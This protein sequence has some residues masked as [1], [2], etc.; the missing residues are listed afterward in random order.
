MSY[1]AQGEK[2][3]L[4]NLSEDLG[5]HLSEGL[6]L[7]QIKDV[8][9]G[10]ESYDEK[11]CKERFKAILSKRKEEEMRKEEQT[12]QDKE[13]EFELQKL[14]LNLEVQKNS[15]DGLSNMSDDDIPKYELKK[16]IPSFDPNAGD[17]ALYLNIF[18]RQLKF[19]KLPETKW[20]AYLIGLLPAEMAK[21]IARESEEESKDYQHV[22]TML[23]KRYKLSAE[24]FRQLFSTHRKTP[25]GTYRDFYFELRDYFE[26]WLEALNVKTFED[27]KSLIIADQIKKKTPE[28]FRTH[29]IDEW[30]EW[31]SPEELADKLDAYDNLR[32]TLKRDMT[33][34]KKKMFNPKGETT[35][36]RLLTKKSN[37]YPK[38]ENS[39]SDVQNRPTLTC[40]GC[41]EPGVIK[42]RCPKCNL[43]GTNS[44][45]R[46]GNVIFQSCSEKHS[47][48]AILNITVNGIF[49][50]ACADS[51]A[52]HCI[53]GELLY[54][55]LK[56][57]G[58]V[59]QK[60]QLTMTLADGGK[61]QV[62]AYKTC[63]DIG[64][65]GRTIKTNLIAL[66]HAKENRTLLGTDFL[67]D[68][69]V[70]LDLKGRKW[71]FKDVPHR[72]YD[73]GEETN[74]CDIK[75]T[76]NVESNTCKLR[77]EEGKQL[78]KE[79]K[80]Q[81]NT[82]LKQ[83]ETI[84]EPGGEDPTPYVEHFIKTQ[85]HP[86]VAVPPYRV[87]PARR[88]ILK[89]EIDRLLNDKIIEPCESPYAAPV[90]LVPKPNGS[91]RLCVDYRKLNSM[92][93]TDT[94]PLPRIDDLLQTARH[95]QFMSTIDLKSGY[96]QV[97]VAI[98]DRDKTAFT[99]PFGT[100]RFLR[101]PFGLKNAPATFQRLIDKFKNGLQ[102]MTILSYLDDI[103]I[104]SQTFEEHIENLRK[105]F[106]RL[107][108]FKLQA[109][110]EKCHFACSQVK[111]LGHYITPNGIEVD[112]EKT[113]AIQ[114]MPEPKNV[115]QVQSFLQTCSWYR[116]F[117]PKFSEIAR[118]LS[119]LTKKASPWRWEQE[120]QNAFNTLKELLVSPPI[121]KQCDPAKPYV[122]RTDASNFALGA[123]LSQGEVP[124]E[125]PIE[126]ASRLLTSA[127]KNYSTTEREALA[128]VWALQKFRGYIEGAEVTVASDHQ[129]LRWLMSLKSPSG[130][131]ARWALQ[132]QEF[133]LKIH[134][135]P[136]KS[137][138]IADMLSRPFN[139]NQCEIDHFSVDL[140]SRN[141]K[142]IRE[143]QLKDDKLRP[144]IES[145]ESTQ[146][147]ENY[148]NWTERGY[149]MNQGVLYR[150]VPDVDTEE[151]QLVVP[152]HEVKNVLQ[153]YH[154]AP[155]AGHYGEEG[156]YHR[157]SQRYYWTGMRPAIAD[158]VKKCPECARY[159][160]TNLKP[161]GLLRTPVQSQ[162]F[163]TLSIDLF[164]PLPESASGKRWIFIVEDCST[165][166]IE[167]FALKSATAKECAVT[168]V[169]EVFLRYGIP[170][171]LISDNGS[172]FI[173]A[174]LQQICFILKIEQSLTPVYHPQANPVERKN[175]DLKPRL[176][177]LVG[178]EH[179]NWEDKLPCIRF[180][181]NTHQCE[182]TGCT[183]AFLQFA[184]E[185]R[186]VDDIANDL[187]PI[188]END[189]FVPE[190]T[191]YLKR[192]SNIS[193]KIRERIEKKQ[194]QRKQQ[195][196]RRRRPLYFSPGDKVWVTTHPKSNASKSKTA[197][198]MPK[199]DGPYVIT[200]QRSPTTYEV[201][202][203][204]K[205]EVPMG[206]YH[207]S[208]LTK[209]LDDNVVPV[210]PL[211]R[212]GRPRNLD[213]SHNLSNLRR[214]KRKPGPSA[215]R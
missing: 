115:K 120:E 72:K 5:I 180:A 7:V 215:R 61:S 54:K 156:T 13:R 190:I 201:A 154:D 197:K 205:P 202:H 87:S 158:Y 27:L 147:D 38:K 148:V 188:I 20:V 18:E 35:G 132:I 42:S 209:C 90:V 62:E 157:I 58:A 134:Y 110:R 84:F 184:R 176:A 159:K 111:Y 25:E 146:R 51:G 29:F 151:A 96:H 108:E 83:Y 165:R 46:F 40:Y 6:T 123:V 187:T 71:F 44:S 52:S 88:E 129:P 80:S 34:V 160:A 206:R 63:V 193:N 53:A 95:T 48:L 10:H 14:K 66:P 179:E 69:G 198:F 16:L 2:E 210:A 144:I 170:R 182:T 99:C 100:Y 185:L 31:N 126:Y 166:W 175:R 23:L 104:L 145:F 173:S 118:P 200:T 130:R 107:R 142:E 30:T 92:T 103:I 11:F 1:L 186:T 167:L 105:V 149:L 37:F 177:I 106:Q 155:T 91:F 41:G 65:E 164:G 140:P 199:R 79:E 208:A 81:L 28:D 169:E 194:D 9:V 196:D 39:K 98:K 162:R 36:T 183:P 75:S 117:I 8:I 137:N 12:R 21:L 112:P 122:I 78:S 212:R 114:N 168:L 76:L 128:V 45:A 32:T 161:A 189:N 214:S 49:G 213:P 125:H 43:S 70:V 47:Q 82:L 93:E 109:N 102:D 141:P 55:I 26:G 68:A 163:E 136:G 116:R 22:K 101:M 57:E 3:D 15:V 121:L 119:N 97:G 204:D 17:I 86:P 85:N 192:F 207:V 127:E 150:F 172:Q 174:V 153:Q 135:I 67:Q 33:Y 211:R 19:L 4:K 73:F 139:E 143:S 50:T 131:L 178:V 203:V 171:R 138:V 94:Y 77:E 56:Q 24:R 133:N 152:S 64:L 181:M 124:D 113:S 60:M 191:P 74:L 59:F 89:S 195:F